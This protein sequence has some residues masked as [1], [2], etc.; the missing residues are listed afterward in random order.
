[1]VKLLFV[2]FNLLGI[3]GSVAVLIVIV[4]PNRDLKYCNFNIYVYNY[5]LELLINVFIF[6]RVLLSVVVEID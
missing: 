3:V 2:Y 5:L 4:E 6:N 1:M